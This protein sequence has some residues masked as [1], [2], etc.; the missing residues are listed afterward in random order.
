[1]A[2]PPKRER[3]R[4]QLLAAGRVVLAERGE[5]LTAT[6]VV[7]VAEVS[8]GTFYNHFT[9]RDDFLQAL[10]RDTLLAIADTS[11]AETEGADPAWRFAL[12]T[13]RV[14]QAAVEDPM[15]GLVIL[16]L[17][18]LPAAPLAEV[19]RHLRADLRDGHASGRFTH[20]ADAV[21][22][23][24]V[25]GTLMA[26]LKRISTTK[27]GARAVAP[28]VARL[29]VALGLDGQEADDLARAAVGAGAVSS[30]R[31]PAAPGR[32]TPAAVR[33]RRPS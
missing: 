31:R 14:L 32:P 9:D 6:D 33:S 2:I 30:P 3:T 16:R 18:E 21:T 20:G 7:Q 28:V 26:S 19:Q 5:A 22:L 25:G 11:A 15:L 24:L 29:L 8:N 17:S 27:A 4:R 13:A 1:V 10:A 23:D 12:A